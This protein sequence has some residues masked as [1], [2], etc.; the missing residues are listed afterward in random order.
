[1]NQPMHFRVRSRVS[2]ELGKL[3]WLASEKEK[4]PN[5]SVIP[6]TMKNLYTSLQAVSGEKDLSSGK[7]NGGFIKDKC[8]RL[9]MKQHYFTALVIYL[10]VAK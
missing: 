9:K 4:T 2:P 8:I 3:T 6:N 10:W 1:M 7:W 5:R